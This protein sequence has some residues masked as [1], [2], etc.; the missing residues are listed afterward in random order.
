M[1]HDPWCFIKI[2]YSMQ[3]RLKKFKKRLANIQM[4]LDLTY[5]MILQMLKDKEREGIRKFHE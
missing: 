1:F 3:V 2:L 4:L 5:C